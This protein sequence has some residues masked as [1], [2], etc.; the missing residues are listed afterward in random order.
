MTAIIGRV[1]QSTATSGTG[2]FVAVDYFGGG[3]SL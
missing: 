1:L 3:E 2:Q